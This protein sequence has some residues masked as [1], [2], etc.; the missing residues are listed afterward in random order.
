MIGC[1]TLILCYHRV[2]DGVQNPFHLCVSPTNFASHLEVLRK[3]ADL[4]TLD[5]I[6]RPSRRPRVVVTFDDGYADNLLNAVPIADRLGVPLTIYVTSGMIGDRRGF[7]WDRLANM[8]LREWSARVDFSVS[9]GDRRIAFKLGGEV[10]SKSVLDQVHRLL[11]PMPSADIDAVLE[12]IGVQLGVDTSAPIDARP[13]T[14]DE[15]GTLGRAAHVT[16]GAHTMDHVLLRAQ[17]EDVQRRTIESS[18]RSLE[19]QLD[20]PIQHFAYPF[21]GVDSFDERTVNIARDAGFATATTT[22][23]GSVGRL[24]DPY[25]LRRRLSMDWKR[26]RFRVQIARW[27]MA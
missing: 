20:R 3:K 25:R 6:G 23:P 16:I 22:L 5:T 17:T 7:W 8:I 24:P 2:A 4:T 18:K 10:P 19:A 14:L 21:G 13:L 15:L 26:G 27:G 12:S 1:P 9:V 11:R